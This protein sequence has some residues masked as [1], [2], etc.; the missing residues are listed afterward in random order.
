MSLGESQQRILDHLKRRGSATI[1]GIAEELDLNVETIRS[2]LRALGDQGWVHRTGRQ[3]RGQGRPEIVYGL[4]AASGALFPN[5]E[6]DLLRDLA[7]YLLGS[8][9]EALLEAFF[10]ERGDQRIRVAMGR[11]EGLAG[12]ARLKEVVCIFNEEGFMAEAGTNEDG[13]LVLLLCHCPQRGLVEV[14]KVPCKVEMGFVRALLGEG[15][16][17]VSYIPSGDSAC[18]YAGRGDGT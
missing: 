14:T 15:L 17:R 6:G 3:K 8:G 9:R 5:R 10:E 4:T 2:H 18:S 7:R 13:R 1:P 16:A 11:V 12:E